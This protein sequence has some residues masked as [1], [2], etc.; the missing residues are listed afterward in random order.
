MTS[1]AD[2]SGAPHLRDRRMR[3]GG[4]IDHCAVALVALR[5]RDPILRHNAILKRAA[6]GR[7]IPCVPIITLKV[8]TFA[9]RDQR[10]VPYLEL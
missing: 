7:L 2:K 6:F 8:K 3:Q 5:L 4:H 1:I 9:Q 10:R